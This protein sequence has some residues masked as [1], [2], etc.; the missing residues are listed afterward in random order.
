MRSLLFAALLALVPLAAEAQL[1]GGNQHVKT[2]VQGQPQSQTLLT[3]T[4]QGAG[5][6]DTQDLVNA[7]Q[8]GVVVF[9]NL[10]AITGT[11]SVVPVI[12]GRDPVSGAYY[13]VCV[14]TA[15]TA[16]G[17]YTLS[18]YP[19]ATPSAGVIC[20]ALLPVVWRVEVRHG[21]GVTPATTGTVSADLIE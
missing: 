12:Q 8:R 5:N 7:Y 11:V 20:N 13:D 9:M 2:N 10:S 18:T 3:M 14:G 6:N 4:A 1:Q 21:A 16:T 19:S 15:R 17:L